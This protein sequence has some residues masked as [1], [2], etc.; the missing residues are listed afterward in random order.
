MSGVE[1]VTDK[2]ITLR[3]ATESTH[4]IVVQYAKSSVKFLEEVKP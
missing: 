1:G 4:E 2:T 3:G